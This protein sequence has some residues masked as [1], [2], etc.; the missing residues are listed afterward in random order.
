LYAVLEE[1]IAI[2]REVIE[3]ALKTDERQ[4]K[5]GRRSDRQSRA[6]NT[7]GAQKR[8][9]EIFCQRLSNGIYSGG[10]ARVA[11]ES[12][13]EHRTRSGDER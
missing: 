10:S 5:K 2:K 8:V 1:R 11:L 7:S 3:P 9:P 13:R 4:M 6:E 12:K